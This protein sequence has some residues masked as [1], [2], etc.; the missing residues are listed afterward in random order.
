[1][2]M[3]I[4]MCV[5]MRAICAEHAFSMLAGIRAA[6]GQHTCMHT[7]MQACVQACMDARMPV[8]MP[9]HIRVGMPAACNMPSTCMQHACS[10]RAAWVAGMD[11]R[12]VFS[13]RPVACLQQT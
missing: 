4:S 6:C 11:G 1:M 10:M 7:C 2:V 5:G 3:H 12:H 8:C 9:A 13:M